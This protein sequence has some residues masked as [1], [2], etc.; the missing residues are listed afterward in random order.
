NVKSLIIVG[1]GE[2][3]RRLA[4]NLR[5]RHDLGYRVLGYVDSDPNF[6]G[7]GVAGAPFLGSLEDLP[8]IIANEVV[9]EVAVALPIKSHYSQIERAVAMLEEQGITTHVLS[10]LFPQKRARSQSVEFA[11][12][13]IVTLRSTPPFG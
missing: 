2:R 7:E 3:G 11:W 8:R 12:A 10:D 1:G 5:L 6:R 13:P 4:A 9:D